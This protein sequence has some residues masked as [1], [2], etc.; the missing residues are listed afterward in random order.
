M[1]FRVPLSRDFDY[2]FGKVDKHINEDFEYKLPDYG[3]RPFRPRGF[4]FARKG[5][6]ITGIYRLRF[7]RGADKII[8]GSLFSSST[9]MRYIARMK[10]DKNG[11][12]TLWV[13]VYPQLVQSFLLV[14]SALISISLVKGF[15]K[16][17]IF[18]IF[19]ALM[20][21]YTLIEIVK[22]SIYVKSEFVKF[23]N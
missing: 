18:V 17:Y 5:N 8:E 11:Q 10:T 4:H 12:N 20:F 23:F 21:I 14:T 1:I 9:H 16:T 2:Y 15:F 3:K 19:F 6:W 22:Q 13:F 7:L